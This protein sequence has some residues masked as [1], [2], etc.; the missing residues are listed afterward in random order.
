[1]FI[2]K[3]ICGKIHLLFIRRNRLIISRVRLLFFDTITIVVHV[4]EVENVLTKLRTVVYANAYA[5]A[6]DERVYKNPQD[7]NPDRYGGGE[8]YPVGNFGFG[9]RYVLDQRLLRF[10]PRAAV[11]DN[12][13]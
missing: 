5:I 12:S 4:Y 7:F 13:F 6:H 3:G 11:S 2:P 8:P 1:M 9:R 10:K